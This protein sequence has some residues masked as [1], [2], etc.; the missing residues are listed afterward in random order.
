LFSSLRKNIKHLEEVSITKAVLFL[1]IVPLTIV[2]LNTNFTRSN[3]LDSIIAYVIMMIYSLIIGRHQ[4]QLKPMGA[5]KETFGISFKII[6]ASM[7]LGWIGIK[8]VGTDNPQ[9]LAGVVYTTEEYLKLNSLLPFIGFAEEFLIVL[10]FMGLFSLLN[11]GRITKFLYSLLLA[12]LIFGF[13][14]AFH[15]P[16]SA[17][18]V[19]GLGHIPY[20]F[21]TVYYRSIIPA[22]IAHIEWD[23]MNFFGH[24]NENLYYLIISSV[25]IIYFLLTSFSKKKTIPIK[26]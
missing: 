16:F 21:A 2:L 11:G 18:L 14:H 23:G 9:G 3:Y 10:T 20:I 17:V 4:L 26:Q 1:S 19:I 15:S 7:I 5:I 6:A 22:I 8:I 25:I 24:Y 13:L 12:S